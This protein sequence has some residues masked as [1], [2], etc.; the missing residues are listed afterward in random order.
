MD[1]IVV[2]QNEIVISLLARSAIGVDSILE[3]V[4]KGKKNP[5]AYI[6]AY[7][8]LRGSLGVTEVAKIAR[9]SKG[10]MSVTLS[11]WEE[12]GIVYDVGEA[13]RPLYKRL[14]VLPAQSVHRGKRKDQ[15]AV[16]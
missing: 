8:A 9:V 4:T 3:T 2:K 7:N 10:T 11:S 16:K 14:L 1:D 5:A 12:E 13:N 15:A 6:R